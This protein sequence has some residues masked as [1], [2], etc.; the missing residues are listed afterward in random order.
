M[1]AFRYKIRDSAGRLI[2]D[3][4][5]T[6]DQR[7]R[8]DQILVIGDHSHIDGLINTLY[9]EQA[10]DIIAAKLQFSNWWRCSRSCEVADAWSSCEVR[11]SY[12]QQGEIAE[13]STIVVLGRNTQTDGCL[14]VAISKSVVPAQATGVFSGAIEG[15]LGTETQG[16]A[17]LALREVLVGGHIGQ[18]LVLE[19]TERLAV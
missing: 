16:I 3:G 11:A 19:Q 5:L 13:L 7:Y 2:Q 6:L 14:V 10:C 9:I 15:I 1:R 17:V 4:E 8:N 18:A 12:G